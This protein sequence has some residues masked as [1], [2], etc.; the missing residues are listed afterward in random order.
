MFWSNNHSWTGKKIQ[1]QIIFGQKNG[2]SSTQTL[3]K[4]AFK[5]FYS[6]SFG[7]K[8]LSDVNNTIMSEL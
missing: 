5:T 3:N 6:Y 8:T 1:N 7:A 2:D 4:W